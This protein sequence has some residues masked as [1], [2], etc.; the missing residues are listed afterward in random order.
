MKRWRKLLI[1]AVLFVVLLLI[2]VVSS[3]SVGPTSPTLMDLDP[4]TLNGHQRL[5]VLAPHCDDETL[6][7]GGLIM[8]A[9]RRGMEIRVIIATNGDGYR[10]A[11]MEEFRRAF[12]HHQDF[13]NIGTLRQQESLSALQLLRVPSDHVYFLSYPDRG[14]PALWNDHWLA[15]D[16][17]RS[18]YSGANQSPYPI[19]YNPDSMYAGEDL[20]ADLRSILEA[21]RPDLIV[22]PHPD[23]V[24][25]DHWGL[26]VFTRL[27]LALMQRDNPGYQP[28]AYAYLVHR[29]DFPSP[30]GLLP[31]ESL[32]PPAALFNLNPHWF[33]L[34]MSQEDTT[35]KWEAIRAY[36]SQLPLLRG[37]LES[38]ARRN[39]LFGRLE[40]AILPLLTDG[41]PLDPGTWQ[42]ED[43]HAVEPVQGDP[44]KDFVVR[45]A[46][47]AA[48]LVALYAGERPDGSLAICAKV[49][50]RVQRTLVYVLR[51]T[52][53][54]PDGVIHYAA[55]RGHPRAG[56]HRATAVGHYVCDEVPPSELGHPWMVFV[57]AEVRGPEVGI[58]DQVA[59]QLVTIEPVGQ[60]AGDT[61]SSQ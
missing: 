39:E 7:A 8:A 40:P 28:D 25:P 59:W 43:G 12:P 2:L 27:A 3:R 6:G 1:F 21:Y 13:I 50:G 42:D 32:L 20:L 48:D 45:D 47:A 29:P 49:R 10:F 41:E 33:R 14:T 11:T 38:F 56:W 34:E 22:Y 57:G 31:E 44:V 4:L 18:P 54:G 26:S 61:G 5:L 17:Y 55:Q 35:L 16:P 24:H 19:T 46:I 36:R 60:P 51:V 53:I 9:H 30:K 15:A 23:D 52:A 58:L 37:L